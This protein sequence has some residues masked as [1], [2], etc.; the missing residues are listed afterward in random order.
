[1][2]IIAFLIGGF[3]VNALALSGSNCLFSSLS[4]ESIDKEQKQ[5]ET[6]IEDL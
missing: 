5:H 1:M 3:H 2:A 4:N 6:A